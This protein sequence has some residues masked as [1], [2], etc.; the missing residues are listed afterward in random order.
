MI[1]AVGHSRAWAKLR[2]IPVVRK[3]WRDFRGE[4][5]E[6]PALAQAAEWMH[7]P[8]NRRL[9]DLLADMGSNEVV[10]YGGPSCVEFTENLVRV[11]NEM[12]FNALFGFGEKDDDQAQQKL[13]DL[14]SSL[15]D[16][17]DA[18]VPPELVLAGRIKD[19]SRTLEQ[20][21]RLETFVRDQLKSLPDWEKRFGQT[22]VEGGRFLTL[23]LDGSMAPWRD[24]FARVEKEEG[25][26][27]ELAKKL[28]GLK[29][30]INVGVRNGYV[31]LSIGIPADRLGRL[32]NKKPLSGRPEL[33][34]LA[35]HAER[36]IT[37][38]TYLSQ[39]FAKR[40]APSKS[41]I[42]EGLEGAAERLKS[43]GLPEETQERIKGDLKSLA[44]DLKKFITEPGARMS[45]SFLNDRGL[46]SFDYDWGERHREV[47][48]QPLTILEH[49]G[50]NPALV[51]A[52]RRHITGEGYA[53]IAKWLKKL[54][55][56]AEEIG[57]PFL[58]DEKR[59]KYHEV[60]NLIFP[61]LKRFD[62]VTSQQLIPALKDGQSAFV[63]DNKLSSRQWAKAMPPADTPVPILEPAIVFGISDPERLREAFG[64][65]RKIVN[66][67]LAAARKLEAPI[68][69]FDVPAPNTRTETWGSLFFYPRPRLDAA[70]ADKQI[71]PVAGLSKT[72]LAL[73]ISPAH[74]QRLLTATPL[75]VGT[76]PI[77][78]AKQPL[79]AAA[80]VNF[81]SILDVIDKWLQYGV[82]AAK[83][84]AKQRLKV[85]YEQNKALLAVARVFRQYSGVTHREDGAW[86]SHAELWVQ[87]IEPQAKSGQ[88]DEGD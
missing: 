6:N 51:V 35:E 80:I 59:D 87:D 69:P 17:L 67:S 44:E 30:T 29:T 88:T 7:E 81:G 9:I 63:V 84:E 47:G 85:Q 46:E 82:Q 58:D 10:F 25:E 18:L 14:L 32:G 77:A 38:V 11:V 65:Y 62:E 1:E 72:Y 73:A 86:V 26:F 16:D 28:K 39:D 13:H 49:V 71:T 57:L 23:T 36:R 41:D 61:L 75:R 43:L 53:F 40:T 8:E 37:S 31:F 3:L 15:S 78:E 60:T 70:G 64:N 55:G 4:L 74:A 50:G 21:K 5:R 52:S 42:D 56:Y 83:G 27:D 66:D 79:S 2:T 45:F 19:P 24:M 20:L 76:G 34:P 33:K 12:R 68:P 48:A 22:T 54:T